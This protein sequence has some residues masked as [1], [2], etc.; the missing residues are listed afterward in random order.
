MISSRNPN[1]SASWVIV[2]LNDGSAVCETWNE[3]LASAVKGDRFRA[4]PILEYL[5][6]LNKSIKDKQK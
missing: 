3:D 4:V 6:N 2:D 1:K 5:G